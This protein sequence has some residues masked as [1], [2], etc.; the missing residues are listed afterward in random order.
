MK[1]QTLKLGLM[2]ALLSLVL[3]GCSTTD[4]DEQAGG[5]AEQ[6]PQDD[7]AVGAVDDGSISGS[8]QLNPLANVDTIFYF[9]FD[10]SLLKAESRA[11]LVQH[12]DVLRNSP[13]SIRLE[14]H[15]DERG[16]RE[17]NLA[18]GERRAN[19]VKEF[20]VLQGVDASYIEVISY[21]EERLADNGS[22]EDSHALNRRVE[23][24]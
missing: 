20:L 18:L 23:L 24:K 2:G 12:A 11:A 19:A 15:A 14:G 8:D 21:G 1:Q 13:R 10:K 22:A 5:A 3:A 16:T 9:D 6:L 7:V 17:Y 4:T